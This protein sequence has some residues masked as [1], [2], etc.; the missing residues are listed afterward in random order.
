MSIKVRRTV[1]IFIEILAPVVIV[2]AL[3]NC[4]KMPL[5][6]HSDAATT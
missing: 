2:Q 4:Y 3:P 1:R 6:A 5:L